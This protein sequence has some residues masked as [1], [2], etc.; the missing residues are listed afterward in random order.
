MIPFSPPR[1]DSKIVEEVA[2]ALYS[3]WITTGP[4]TK[5]FEQELEHFTGASKVLCLNSATAGLEVMLRWFGVGKGDEVIVPAYTY[6]ATA[7]VIIHCGA[8]PVF[9]D[10]GDDFNLDVDAV[11]RAV[12]SK[13]KA[14][15]T[16]DIGGL[17]CDYLKIAE[18]NKSER[19]KSLFV[20]ATEEQALLGR[21]LMIADA[22]H[23]LGATY[24]GCPVGHPDLAD[25]TVFSFHAVKNLTTAEGG[26]VCLNLPKPF[27]NIELYKY[28]CVKSLHGQNKDAFQKNQ[29]GNWRYDIIEAGYKFNMT[30][31]QAAMGLVELRR[32]RSDMLPKRKYIFEK[33]SE[34]FKNKKWAR[35]PVTETD[36]KQTSYHAFMLRINGI[37]EEQRDAIIQ[38]IFLAGVAVNVHFIP[39]P[40]MT[41]YKNMGYQIKDYPKAY[42]LFASEIS[43]PVYYSLTDEQIQK[44]IWVVGV[45]VEENL[46]K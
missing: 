17:P 14:I 39:L 11:G 26:A 36:I 2:A 20:P 25:T 27:D 23:S 29:M 38:D 46:I 21:P 5:M 22:A 33:Y 28:L 35:L 16:V 15:I 10:S 42:K 8:K 37:S 44:I 34:G 43:L 12:T 1:I 4:R 9:V 40:M 31:V 45:A 6:A 18:L 13:T 19:V 3:G 30:D 41:L 24:A 32:Y 7:N